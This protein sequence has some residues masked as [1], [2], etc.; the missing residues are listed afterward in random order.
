MDGPRKLKVI[1]C[2]PSIR[3]NYAPVDKLGSRFSITLIGSKMLSFRL[4]GEGL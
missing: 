1:P 3:E 2:I 4:E